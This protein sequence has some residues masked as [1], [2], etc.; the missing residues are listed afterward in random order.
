MFHQKNKNLKMRIKVLGKKFL[1]SGPERI[2]EL[3]FRIDIPIKAVSIQQLNCHFVQSYRHGE[4]LNGHCLL[5]ICGPNL[6]FSSSNSLAF[7]AKLKPDNAEFK[8][9]NVRSKLAWWESDAKNYMTFLKS[10]IV[11]S[12]I[13]N[14]SIIIEIRYRR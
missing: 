5:V 3:S 7:I 10:D 2:W 1:F 4:V 14:I 12:I 6:S 13:L 9:D 8:H 11:T